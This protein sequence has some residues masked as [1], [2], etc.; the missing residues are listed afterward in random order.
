MGGN[1]I[2][3]LNR[4]QKERF[5]LLILFF[6]TGIIFLSSYALL[7]ITKPT[8]ND[9]ILLILGNIIALI[10][11]FHIRVLDEKRDFLDDNKWHK[12]R[13]IQKGLISLKELSIIDYI[14]LLI[15]VVILIFINRKS[16]LFFILGLIFVF[17]ASNDFFIRK[18]IIKRIVLYHLLNSFQ[19]II[20]LFFIYYWISSTI[21]F[22]YVILLHM[23]MVYGCIFLVEV[24]RK[25]SPSK[26]LEYKQDS[27]IS[28]LGRIGTFLLL[29]LIIS[30]IYASYVLLLNFLSIGIIYHIIGILLFVLVMIFLIIYFFRLNK[31]NLKLLEL[32]SLIYYLGMNLLLFIP[33]F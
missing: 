22:D 15:A 5:P 26:N 7:F 4:Y 21:K 12:N 33:L 28:S 23:I 30:V 2:V 8:L 29:I 6:T 27:Y 11:L 19:M 9:W 1:I 20:L 3:R 32:F 24:I 14:M 31:T 13:P 17:F 10:F 25:V 18:Y 16:L